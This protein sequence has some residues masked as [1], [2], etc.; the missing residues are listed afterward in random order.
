MDQGLMPHVQR[1]VENGAIGEISTLRPPLSPMLWTSIATGKRP[2]KHGVHG[3]TEPTP[4]GQGVQPITN[5]SRTSKALWNILNQNDLRSIV[6]GWWP[7]HPVEPIHGVM[8]SDQYHRAVGPVGQGWPLPPNSVHPPELAETLAGLRVHPDLL[9]PE[10]VEPFVPLA[11]EIDQDIDQ[12]LGNLMRTLAECITIQS[13][14]AWLLDRQPWDFFAVY[15]DSLDHFCHAFM[16]YHPPRQEW[17]DERD[18]ELYHNVVSMAYRLHDR[19]LGDLLAKTGED[20]TVILMS[21]HGFHPDHLRPS[22]IPAIPAGPAI[23]HRD[24]G[25]LAI[26]GP[27]IRKDE[28]LHGASVLDIAP[29]ILTLYGLPAGEDMDGKVLLQAFEEPPAVTWIPSWEEVPGDDGCHPAHIRFDPLAAHAAM[30]QLAALGYIEPPGEGR[31]EGVEKTIRELRYNLGEAYQDAGRHAEA[32]EIFTELRTADPAEQRFSVRLFV[33][34]QALG[35]RDEMRRI[36]YDLETRKRTP[37]VDYLKAQVLTAEGRCE[38]ALLALNEMAEADRLQPPLLVQAA[39]LYFRL[40]RTAD[41]QRTFEK[42]L[43]ADPDNPHAWLG[44]C[45]IALRQEE[46]TAAAQCA[47]EAL[48]RFHDDPVA[49]FLLGNALTGL[50]EYDR[51]AQ[52]YRAAIAVNPHFPQAHEKLAGLLER[53]LGDSGAARQHRSLGAQMRMAVRPKVA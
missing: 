42:A 25:I 18:F 39:H 43:A 44:L 35:F 47:L 19:M 40:G 45:R 21:D 12:R 6:V 13:A 29:T 53:H 38:E 34:C 49:H 7:S 5:L 8:V 14:A 31:A 32:H 27:G 1:L 26:A 4:D 41:S 16:R 52:A 20:T 3:F 50:R 23:E 11:R 36:V 28:L 33:S 10:I 24:L 2:F 17:I 15:F 9:T 22:S 37:L 48:Q 51:A 46:F 30:R